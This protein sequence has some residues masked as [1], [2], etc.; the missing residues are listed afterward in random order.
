MEMIESRFPACYHSY[1]PVYT[2]YWTEC[3]LILFHQD[4][5]RGCAAE[6]RGGLLALGVR[7]GGAL[8]VHSSF[9]SLGPVPG[10][11]R[12]LVDGLEEALGP[13]GTLLMPA[14]SYQSVTRE[15][16][17]FD[18]RNTPSCV[19][20]V[21]E[22]F[23][24]AEGTSRSLHPTHS[25]CGRG[26]L[27]GEL[28]ADHARDATPCGPNSP[29]N[30]LRLY[31]GQ[32]LMLGCGLLHNTTM[33][34]AEEAARAPYIFDPAPVEYT[35]VGYDGVP[36]KAVHT[37]HA[38]FPQHYDR[39]GPGLMGRGLAEGR[40]LEAQCWLYDAAA[41]WEHALGMLKEDVYCFYKD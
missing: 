13:E 23:R 40:V 37:R 32:I 14:L 15:Q 29:F 17:V 19:G 3:E 36:H 9:K 26:R 28:F 11:I 22:Y 5:A 20:A 8:L 7:P 12:T 27:A 30:R 33:H 4:D 1:K 41:L 18:V 6:I 25:M 34:A 24:T 21:P 16:P 39:V 31:G 2:N 10:G 38:D 35:L